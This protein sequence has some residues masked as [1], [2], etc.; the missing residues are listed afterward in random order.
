[1]MAVWE[2]K[3]SGTRE[4]L[5]NEILCSILGGGFGS[6]FM[7][8]REK[9]GY[10]Y[11]VNCNYQAFAENDKA[12]MFCYAGLNKHNIPKTKE[13]IIGQETPTS[14]VGEECPL[15][16]I[17]ARVNSRRSGVRCP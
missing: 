3:A 2:T 7:E 17:K 6:R 13:L 15:T 14:K 8:I 1:M 16:L 5:L 9:Y 4:L 12:F 11:T 10:A